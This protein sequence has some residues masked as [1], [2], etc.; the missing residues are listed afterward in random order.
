MGPDTGHAG[1]KRYPTISA[2]RSRLDGGDQ[3]QEGWLA[4]GGAAPLHDGEVVRVGAGACYGGSGVARVLL[5]CSHETR[6]REG[7]TA[8]KRLWAG[9]NNSGE[10]FRPLGEEI[11]RDRA[12]SRFNGGGVWANAGALDGVGLAG[13]RAGAASKRCRTPAKPKWLKA[14]ANRENQARE[15][16]SHLGAELEVAWRGLQ[17]A[18]RPTRHARVSDKAERCG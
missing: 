15:R 4:A 16:M 6:V 14:G 11:D 7:R 12:R 18:R 17:R 3:S 1:A 8:G 13:H 10:E 9:R 2:V 5:V